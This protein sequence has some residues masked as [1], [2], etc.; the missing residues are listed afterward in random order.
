MVSLETSKIFRSLSA[1]ELELLRK[2]AKVQSYEAGHTIFTEGDEGDGLYL[3]STGLVQISAL[4]HERERRTLSR[5]G[6][7]DFFGEMAVLD[8]GSR[9]ATA[10]AEQ[11]T[12]LFF[13]PRTVI[14]DLL[15][16]SPRLAVSLMR[17]F[18]LRLRE[19][20]RQYIQEVLQAE[21]LSLVGRFARAI[22]HDFKNPLNVIGIASDLAAL[23]GVTSEMRQVARIRIRKQIDHLSGMINELMEFTRGTKS[24]IVLAEAEYPA[25][26]ERLLSDLRSEVADSSVTFECENEPPPVS[27]LIDPQ[28]LVHVFRNLLNNAVDA[29]PKGGKVKFRFSINGKYVVTQVEDTGP[30]IPKE[31]QPR[32]FEA[33]ATYGK[34]HGTGL[35]L[36]ICKRIIE[37]HLGWIDGRNGASGGAVF[38]FAL[39]LASRSLGSAA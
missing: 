7:G 29:M 5:V 31:I 11:A 3:I 30:G 18:S 15:E 34:A 19:F 13:I 22:V 14:L 39:P 12:T 35:G 20:N 23:D 16:R 10:M 37:D 4:V 9:S 36:S 25:F 32:L 28:R 1:D 17:E 24:S 6:P 38:E 26:I 2:T 33:F 21:R 8:S 27:I